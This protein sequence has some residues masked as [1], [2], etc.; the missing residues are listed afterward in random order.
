MSA[1]SPTTAD[2]V[3]QT[4]RTLLA[5]GVVLAVRRPTGDGLVEL[6]RAA[7]RGGVRVLE[8]T[9]T[10]PGAL[11][12]ITELSQEEGLLVGA[13][14][15]L[16]ADDVR[17]V[18]EAGGRFALSP[19]FDGDVL[20]ESASR[21][22]LAIP[23]AATPK[24]ILTAHRYGASIVKVFPAAALGGPDFLRY[25]RGPLPDIPL[26]PTSGP[27]ST[28]V[29]D[30]LEAGAVAVGVGREIL[31]APCTPES[32]ETAARRMRQAMDDAR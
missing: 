20:D 15:V 24:E 27:D 19:V 4:R 7:A 30:Y 1:V 3:A 14:T 29:S 2:R 22:L 23:G 6:C 31:A 18:D 5:D 8:I 25:V 28:N 17:R 16:S 10:T 26:M 32:V 21:G 9:L 11:E 13:G 12:A